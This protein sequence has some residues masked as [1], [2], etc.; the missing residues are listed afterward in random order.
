MM[1]RHVK[2]DVQHAVRA[3]RTERE[4]ECPGPL[5]MIMAGAGI[6]GALHSMQY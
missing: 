1:S 2:A 3:A 5:I 6:F 4:V